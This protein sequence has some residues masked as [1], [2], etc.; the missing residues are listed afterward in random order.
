MGVIITAAVCPDQSGFYT[1]LMISSVV[2]VLGPLN[3]TCENSA[4]I[5]AGIERRVLIYPIL[6][7]PNK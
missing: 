3:N 6:F 1:K 7:H 4:K 2:M 5:F